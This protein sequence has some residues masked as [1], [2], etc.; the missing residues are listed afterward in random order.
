MLDL[1]RLRAL[2]AVAVHGSVSAAALALGYT[3]SAVSQAIA[4]LER[5]T[6]TTL[7][8]RR[9]RGVV[10]TDAAVRLSATARE[11]LVLVERAETELEERR[12]LPTGRLTVG[13]FPTAARDLLPG[14]LARLAREHPTVDARLTEVDPHL[15]V[16]LVAQGVVDLAVAHDWDINPLP[17]PE[18]MERAA[19]GQDPCDVLVPAGHPLTGRA[20]PLSTADLAHE[21]WI[22]QPPGTVCHDWL[23]RAL[24]ATGHEPD[25]VH[26]VTEYQ[27]QLALVAAGLGV[28]LVPRLGRGPLPSG[29]V[30]LGLEP[31]PVRR[32]FAYWRAGAARRPAITETVRLLREAVP[33][34]P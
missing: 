8:E 27:T 19:L 28:A 24:R 6:R 29:V 2:H 17:A 7:L 5:E 32:L 15:S 23:V 9:G 21:R 30:A 22:C 33:D 18:G 31:V 1:P 14:V 25:L 20:A 34:T 3:P 16:G 10:L 11:L 4:K 26:Q 12:G 13:A